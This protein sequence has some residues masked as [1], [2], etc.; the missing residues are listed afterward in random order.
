MTT[1]VEPIASSA[2]LED[3]RYVPPIEIVERNKII[4]TLETGKRRPIELR[5]HWLYL[6]QRAHQQ[7]YQDTL[8]IRPT[9][10]QEASPVCDV[11]AIGPDVGKRR[12]PD[13]VRGHQHHQVTAQ[14]RNPIRIGDAVLVPNHVTGHPWG[15][16]AVPDSFCDV[17]VDEDVIEG[18]IEK[19]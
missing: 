3:H 7:T 10:G 12:D 2:L 8:I 15:I 5:G 18:I 1:A 6:R 19:A 11:I 16:L 9:V 17:F 4:L 13:K 14:L